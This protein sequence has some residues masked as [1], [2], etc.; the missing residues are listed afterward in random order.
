MT[1]PGQPKQDLLRIIIVG[2]LLCLVFLSNT[3]WD[4]EE[5]TQ[6]I[7]SHPGKAI[8]PQTEAGSSRLADEGSDV[9]SQSR[10]P[11]TAHWSRASVAPKPKESAKAVGQAPTAQLSDL[12]SAFPLVS[13]RPHSQGAGGQRSAGQQ[14]ARA[15]Q[16]FAKAYNPLLESEPNPLSDG[17]PNVFR[18]E[19]TS[20]LVAG[21]PNRLIDNEP[22]PFIDG[23]PSRFATRPGL[24]P[25]DR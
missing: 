23:E 3:I 10:Q 6:S 25:H 7:Q 13:S 18:D 19:E 1:T 11:L 5:D 8:A 14:S 17:E 20:P 21:E 15:R 9:S 16:A 12:S 22:N 2:G 24:P 4:S